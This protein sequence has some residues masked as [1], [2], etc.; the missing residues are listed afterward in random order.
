MALKR[1]KFTPETARRF[2]GFSVANAAIVAASL[3]CGCEAYR[4]VFT[5][6]RWKAQG[7]Q[8]QRGEK[9]IRLPLLKQVVRTDAET[10]EETVRRVFGRSAVFC[11]HQVKPCEPKASASQSRP[12]TLGDCPTCGG[13]GSLAGGLQCR[14]CDGTGSVPGPVGVRP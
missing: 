9:A 12:R 5:Y 11:R 8:V 1:E 7:Y 10:G 13:H 6:N 4:D 2:D 3:P 14:R